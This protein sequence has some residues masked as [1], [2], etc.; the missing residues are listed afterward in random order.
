MSS[1]RS[2]T[3]CFTYFSFFLITCFE[4]P[5]CSSIGEKWMLCLKMFFPQ[6]LL[7]LSITSWEGGILSHPQH[8]WWICLHLQEVNSIDSVPLPPLICFQS[9]H[10]K[11]LYDLSHPF[12]GL[13]QGIFIFRSVPE[14]FRHTVPV[15]KCFWAVTS[16]H[17][18]SPN[19]IDWDSYRAITCSS[20]E[21]FYSNISGP[22]EPYFPW[23]IKWKTGPQVDL[24]VWSIPEL[25]GT[26]MTEIVHV[27]TTREPK[28]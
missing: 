2:C 4:D 13:I 12:T 14:T 25:T 16:C 10:N 18:L 20:T 19:V 5:V 6:V 27:S 8:C 28:D 21:R 7:K 1:L 11:L 22:V 3:W 15:L 17:F 23:A 24:W 26:L 9:L